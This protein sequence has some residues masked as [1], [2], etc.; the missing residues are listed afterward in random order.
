MAILHGVED[1]KE[2]PL[3]ELVVSNVLTGGKTCNVSLNDG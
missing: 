1:L 2:D 3:D